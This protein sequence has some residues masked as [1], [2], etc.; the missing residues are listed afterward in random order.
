MKPSA[1]DIIAVGSLALLNHALTLLAFDWYGG[2]DGYSYDVCGMQLLSGRMFD[3]FPV[4]LREPFVPL[5]KNILYLLFE[6]R[7]YALGVLIHCLGI[8]TAILACRLG[9]RF[10]RR[11][12]LLLGLLT[13]AYLPLSVYFHHISVTTFYIPALVISADRLCAWLIKPTMRRVLSLAC[14]AVLLFLIKSEALFFIPAV[15]VAGLRCRRSSLQIAAFVSIC[16]CAYAGI[17]SVYYVKLGYFGLT[18]KTGWSLFERAYRPPD[19]LFDESAGPACA[20]VARIFDR[21]VVRMIN[22]YDRRSAQMTAFTFAQKELGYKEAD[23]LFRN[24]CIESIRLHLPEFVYYTAVRFAAHLGFSA[25]HGL[26]HKEFPSETDTGHMW[27][28]DEARMVKDRQEFM[29]VKPHLA[30]IPNPLQWE[31]GILKA[32]FL[33]LARRAIPDP[34]PGDLFKFQQNIFF[35]PDGSLS[36]QFR[37]DGNMAERFWMLRDL[38]RFF[39]WGFWGRKGYNKTA[40]SAL[41]AWDVFMPSQNVNRYFDAAMMILWL[42]AIVLSRSR[43][44]QCALG[45]LL[46]YVLGVTVLQCVFSDNF[47]GRFALYTKIFVWLGGLCGMTA[48]WDTIREGISEKP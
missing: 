47:G 24:A 14:C 34:D 13:A 27:G 29:M 42:V 18:Y 41:R 48:L 43:A 35:Y 12:G 11:V 44:Q 9:A 33:R 20:K 32:K 4:M 36:A 19:R 3:I 6:A 16:L 28:F 38:D 39:Y 7:P 15:A 5:A 26:N 46:L 21:D 22:A 31:R 30:R 23:D 37:S 45:G 17:A 2:V 25:P 40:L 10:N 8:V 1:R